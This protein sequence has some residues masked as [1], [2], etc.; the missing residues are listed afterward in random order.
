MKDILSFFDEYTLKARFLPACIAALPLMSI[1]ASYFDWNEFLVANIVVGFLVGLIV[2]YLFSLFARS[3]GRKVESK[4]LKKWGGFPTTQ[5]LR[6]RDSTLSS[7]K[8]E[9]IHELLA[10]KSEIS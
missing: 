8:K 4:I 1:I 6:H 2:I 7:V 3:L 10:Q 5:F 9:K